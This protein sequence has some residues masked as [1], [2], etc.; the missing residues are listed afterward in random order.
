MRFYSTKPPWR[1]DVGTATPGLF[2]GKRHQFYCMTAFCV[3]FDWE[4]NQGRLCEQPA[5]L[6]LEVAPVESSD[7]VLFEKFCKTFLVIAVRFCNCEDAI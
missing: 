7:Q 3:V 5:A 6:L 2:S 4:G 1:S